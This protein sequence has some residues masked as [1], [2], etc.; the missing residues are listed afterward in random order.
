MEELHPLD[1]EA[2]ALWH[3][4]LLGCFAPEDAIAP[5][6]PP[7]FEVPRWTDEDD[8]EYLGELVTCWRCG[9]EGMEITCCD[10]ICHGVGYCIHGDGQ[11]FCPTCHGEGAI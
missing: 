9:G 6:E 5:W 1:H 8:G 3:L 7:G 10:D 11:R 4:E 2:R